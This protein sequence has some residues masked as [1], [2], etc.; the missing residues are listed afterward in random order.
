MTLRVLE[1]FLIF[2]GKDFL[3]SFQQLQVRILGSLDAHHDAPPPRTQTIHSSNA[4]TSNKA[5]ARKRRERRERRDA[6]ADNAANAGEAL[7]RLPDHLVVT[8]ILR[9]DY[10]D[11][12]ADLA[13]LPAVSRAMRDAVA[14]T[15]LEFEELDEDRA[16]NLGCLSAVKRLQR[17]G[18]LSRQ[19]YLCQAAARSG[20][21][22]ELKALRADGWPWD[23]ATCAYAARGGHLEVL[24]WLRENGCPWDSDTCTCPWNTNICAAAA[25][26]GHLEV[27]Q[28][29]RANGRPWN[30]Y[31][32]SRAAQGGHLEVLQWARANGC[33][34]DETLVNIAAQ[35]G[36]EAVVRALIELGADVNKA[37]DIGWTALYAAAYNGHE[38]VVRALIEAD[39]DVNKAHDIGW[40][41]LYAAA[42]KGHETGLRALKEAGADV[43]QADN[44]VTP[45]FIAA[46]RGGGAGA[47][48]GGRGRQQG[49]E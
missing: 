6:N 47:D 4:M 32:C 8:L 43:N 19:E 20:Q 41:P 21:L 11:D 15:G 17:G 36:H 31:T 48:R 1:N 45:L 3:L 13:R 30:A 9:S 18:R 34:W 27:L 28:W 38:A 5:R 10:F 23:F 37:H 35:N 33:P 39:T 49:K 42:C 2:G 12:P 16:V 14:A 46:Q 44:G 29:A 25:E 22:E 26:G 7:P 24:Q 40:T